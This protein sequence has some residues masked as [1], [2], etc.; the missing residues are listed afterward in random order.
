MGD[1]LQ[2]S[3]AVIQVVRNAME[4]VQNRPQRHV[5]VLLTRSTQDVQLQVSDTG[6]G[7]PTA[8]RQLRMH[9]SGSWPQSL[10]GIGLFVV[11]SILLRHRG[12]LELDNLVTGGACVTLVLPRHQT[13]GVGAPNET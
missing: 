9:A 13:E 11:H 4:A 3:Q 10:Q 6:P 2:L 1:A 8:L 5:R 12:R 7:L